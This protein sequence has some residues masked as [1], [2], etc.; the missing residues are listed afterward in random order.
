M[1]GFGQEHAIA[2]FLID[3]LTQRFEVGVRFRQVL[4]GSAF[5]FVEVGNGIQSNAVDPHIEPEIEHVLHFIV[6]LGMVE[7][8]VRLMR[9]KA[10]PIVALRH[11]IQRPV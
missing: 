11:R 1:I 7:V 2:I 6:D 4:A 10:V 5:A 3:V 9:V 8:Q